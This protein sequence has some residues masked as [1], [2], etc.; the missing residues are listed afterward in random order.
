M[1]L[2]DKILNYMTGRESTSLS[3]LY[4]T[5]SETAE[6]TIRGRVNEAT[7][8]RQLIRI[9]RGKYILAGDDIDA[10]IIEGNAL[11]IVPQI[12]NTNIKYD[13][14]FL[15]IPYNLG[16]QKGGNRNLANYNLIEPETFKE[17]LHYATKLLRNEDSLVY[18]MIAG[19]KSSIKKAMKYLEAFD[20]TE[21]KCV[22][23]GSYT[24]LTKAGKVCNMGKYK[25]PP[26]LIKAYNKKGISSISQENLDFRI[27]RPPLPVSGGYPTQ[28]PREL[29]DNI[30][31]KSTKL[32]DLVLDPFGGSGEMLSAVLNAGRRIHTFDISPKS[33]EEFILPKARQYGI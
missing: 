28:K 2:V 12:C 33:I 1:R 5:F 16:G 23:E 32:K 29:L 3:E 13:L 9:A 6:T 14:I 25:M 17:F 11:S 30:I 24:K 10:V 18:M 20:S 4:R 7:K 31:E 22:A 8:S 27:Q 21:L 15:D 19:G 26:E